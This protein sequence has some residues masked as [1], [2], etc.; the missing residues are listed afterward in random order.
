MHINVGSLK[1]SAIKGFSWNLFDKIINQV[2]SFL[3][4][5]Y[6]SRE[7][8]PSDF[9][10]IAMLAIFL[11]ISQTI[12]DSGFSQA[13]VQKSKAVSEDDMS[14]VFYINISISI[15][16]YSI[17]YFS[18]PYIASFYQQD[19]LVSLSRLLFL[20]LIINSFSLV[21]RAKLL[22]VLDFKSQSIINSIS[23]LVSA[24]VTVYMVYKG[25]T[26]WSLV[27]MALMK[28][29]ANA[30]LL[31]L[32]SKWYP[33]LLFSFKSFKALFKFG[34]NLLIV[35][36]ISS[37]VQNL[38]LILIGRFFN[39]AQVGYFHQS[40]NYTNMLSTTLSSVTQGVTYPLMAS[41]QE[42]KAR[43]I[44]IYIKVMGVIT[45]ITFPVFIGFAAITEEFVLM[46]LGEQ[47]GPIIPIVI[48]LSF[49]RL[50]TPISSL[51]LS[52]LNARGR[53]DL[54]LKTELVKLPMTIL[55]LFIAIPYGIIGVAF[56]QLITTLLSFFINAYYPGKLFNFGAKEQLRQIV[57]IL[58][59][60]LIMYAC[61][62][63]IHTEDLKLQMA[64]KIVIGVIVYI[65]SCKLLK[66]QAYSDILTIFLSKFSK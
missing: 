50:I 62:Y 9:G 15:L 4:L 54:F 45:F 17:L 49:A 27:A 1:Q 51:N 33:K 30:I 48:I 57:P 34:S 14:T 63:S 60:S 13:L 38:Y 12:I 26:Y 44:R 10:L 16:L 36:V 61:I 2:G 28:A 64:L 56:S 18:A 19:E 65:F 8:S 66:V 23:T 21:P 58:L 52:I 6:L 35:G 40:Y 59:S 25:Y 20:V 43:L 24:L 46:F 32:F 22:I 55:A 5:I 42:D 53:S 7:L 29:L 47:W 3:L 39:V 37:I 11:A 41:I 31:T